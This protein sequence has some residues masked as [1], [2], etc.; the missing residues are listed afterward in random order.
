MSESDITVSSD[1][2]KAVEF[3]R[4]IQSISN[5]AAYNNINFADYQALRFHVAELFNSSE[6]SMNSDKV[7]FLGKKYSWAIRPLSVL[8]ATVIPVE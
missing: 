3:E 5:I 2:R 7:Y 6:Q 1:V 4:F 8:F